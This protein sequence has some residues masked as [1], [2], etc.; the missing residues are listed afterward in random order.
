MEKMSFRSPVDFL[1]NPILWIGKREKKVYLK[2]KIGNVL[3]FGCLISVA[4]KV[5]PTIIIININTNEFIGKK[6]YSS[7]ESIIDDG[8]IIDKRV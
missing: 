2:R 5:D 4:N 1:N 6:E 7:T 3:E 8:W